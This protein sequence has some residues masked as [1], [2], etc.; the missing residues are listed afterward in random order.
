MK[1]ASG[2]WVQRGIT[3]FEQYVARLIKRLYRE[4][5]PHSNTVESPAIG[6]YGTD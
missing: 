5:G 2:D 4:K 1:I 3:R 6:I